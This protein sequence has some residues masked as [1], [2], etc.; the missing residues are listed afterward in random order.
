MARSMPWS[1]EAVH[2]PLP[3]PPE[4][5]AQTVTVTA[6]AAG[7]MGPPSREPQRWASRGSPAV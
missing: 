6:V 2:L 5:E 4:P 3:L 7:R 1:P